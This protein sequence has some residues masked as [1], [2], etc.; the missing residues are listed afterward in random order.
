MTLEQLGRAGFP[1]DVL[2]ALD[3]LTRRPGEDCGA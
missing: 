2:E 1:T 3:A